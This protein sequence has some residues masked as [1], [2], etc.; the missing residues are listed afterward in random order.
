MAFSY[1]ST[2]RLSAACA[3][4]TK[5]TCPVCCSSQCELPCRVA[6]ILSDWQIWTDDQLRP[7]V[8]DGLI[9]VDESAIPKTKIKLPTELG[10]IGHRSVC[11]TKIQINRACPSLH[12]YT[13]TCSNLLELLQQTQQLP[14][15]KAQVDRVLQCGH[16]VQV[17]CHAKAPLGCM[18]WCLWR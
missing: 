14:D 1:A 2:Q 10:F 6:R 5:L 13:V 17:A 12:V 16:S 8:T 3:R 11:N 18:S 9:Q 4:P 7:I 15:C